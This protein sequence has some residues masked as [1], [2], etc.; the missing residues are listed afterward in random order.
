MRVVYRGIGMGAMPDKPTRLLNV[1]ELL[2]RRPDA[3][4][5]FMARSMACPGCAMAPFETIE[6][7]AAVY[8]VDLGQFLEDLGRAAEGQKEDRT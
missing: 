5:V 2:R 3:A 4:A 7:A 6:D 1:S 8:E